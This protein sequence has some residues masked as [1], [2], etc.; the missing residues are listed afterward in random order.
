MSKIYF[1]P[2][3]LSLGR[4]GV[5]RVQNISHGSI[6]RLYAAVV[7]TIPRC[8]KKTLIRI[9]VCY[10]ESIVKADELFDNWDQDH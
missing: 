7:T 1:Q 9:E 6:K 8:H 10:F 2:G 3:K 5:E 4:S